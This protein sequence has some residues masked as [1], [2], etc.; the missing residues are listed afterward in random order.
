MTFAP[1]PLRP[2]LPLMRQRWSQL[3]FAH[4]PVAP[5]V[6]QPYLPTRLELDLFE[7]QA[8]LG[9]VPFTMSG[10]RPLGLPAVPGL[11]NLHEL[12]VRTYARLDGVPGVWFL[13]LDAT[14]PLGVWAARNLFHLPYLHARMTLTETNGTL[15]AK[16]ERTHPGAA[17]A[18]F[19]ASWTPGRQLPASAPGTLQHFLTE[20]Y[21]LYTAGPD[22]QSAIKGSDLWR[23]DVYH[24]PWALRTATLHTWES[25]VV[26][27]HCLP[28]LAGA[29]LLYAADALDVWVRRIQRV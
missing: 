18:T 14:Q 1:L 26:E 9:V 8:W 10:I 7:G 20:R 6:L 29:P 19:A 23:G 12:N 15:H 3:L 4:W 5:E 25:T 16:A 2:R 28:T 24:A 27:S 13:S 11:S 22:L 17:P 21:H